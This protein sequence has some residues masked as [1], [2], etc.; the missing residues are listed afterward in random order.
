MAVVSIKKNSK[1]KMVMN[2]G[3]DDNNKSVIKNKTM[4][5]AR[6]EADDQTLFEIAHGF[7][8]LQKHSLTGVFKNVE[9]ELVEE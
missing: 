9:F 8:A 2:A 5:H 7:A 6:A 4:Q 1:L 3:L